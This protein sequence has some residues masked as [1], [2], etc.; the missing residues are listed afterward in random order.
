MD[1]VTEWV[2]EARVSNCYR[3][4][5]KNEF[6]QEQLTDTVLL[7]SGS[8]KHFCNKREFHFLRSIRG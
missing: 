7:Y 5:G 8:S 4:K 2:G 6:L 1:W 3:L